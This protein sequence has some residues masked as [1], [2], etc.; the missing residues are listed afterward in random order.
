[1]RKVKLHLRSVT[2]D[3]L[4]LTGGR[5]TVTFLAENPASHDARMEKMEFLLFLNDR[6]LA[7]GEL[8]E[9]IRIP[10]RGHRLLRIPVSF[11]WMDVGAGLRQ[12]FT[13]DTLWYRV[14]GNAF[15]DT[16]MGPLKLR[17]LERT[18]SLSR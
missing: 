16:P 4:N 18:R 10:A 5:L 3:D 13:A 7:T 15:L 6:Q 8:T 11:R 2:V 9:Q 14:E 12:A 1:L 17:I